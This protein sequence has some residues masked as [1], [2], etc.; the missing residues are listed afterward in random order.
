M[1]LFDEWQLVKNA[2]FLT[3][4][5]VIMDGWPEQN[6]VHRPERNF[7]SDQMLVDS[8]PFEKVLLQFRQEREATSVNFLVVEQLTQFFRQ[9]GRKVQ[10]GAFDPTNHLVRCPVVHSRRTPSRKK[11]LNN[12]KSLIH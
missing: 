5:S 9:L 11:F 10:I 12:F 1:P 2:L 7:A 6:G 4:N 8:D 3:F